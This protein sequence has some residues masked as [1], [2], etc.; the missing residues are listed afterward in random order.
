[1]QCRLLVLACVLQECLS[2]P[3][4]VHGVQLVP[5]SGLTFIVWNTTHHVTLSCLAKL[6]VVS[7]LRLAEPWS[8]PLCHVHA[9]STVLAC[10]W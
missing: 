8:E 10:I 2:A 6:T 7:V 4:S 9:A 3:N 5:K 1:M